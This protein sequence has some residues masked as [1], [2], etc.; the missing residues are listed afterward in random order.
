MSSYNTIITT[1]NGLKDLARE[2]IRAYSARGKL[3]VAYDN[4]ELTI[5]VTQ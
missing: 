1:V 3:I 2:E 4:Y 5:N